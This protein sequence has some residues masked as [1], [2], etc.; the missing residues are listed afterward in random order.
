MQ[1]EYKSYTV[2]STES[3]KRRREGAS[4]AEGSESIFLTHGEVTFAKERFST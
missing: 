1:L 3:Q 2:S 4:A